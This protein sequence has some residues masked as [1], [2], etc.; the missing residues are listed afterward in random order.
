MAD[1]QIINGRVLTPAGELIEATLGIADGVIGETTSSSF[2]LDARDLLVLPGIID[3]HGDAFERQLMPRPGVGFPIDVALLETDRQMAANG[4]TTAF[5][6]VT[7]SWEPGLRDASMAQAMA[8]ALVALKGQLSVDTRFHLRHE[9]HN[10]AAEAMILEWIAAG[11]IA[12]LSFNDH[13]EDVQADMAKP[14]KVQQYL[15]RT[16]LQRAAWDE[17]VAEVAAHGPDV[18]ASVSRLAAAAREAGI[19]MMSHDDMSPQTRDAFYAMGVL[20]AEF[21]ETEPTAKRALEQGGAVV[22]G[23]PNVVRGKS[24]TTAPNASDMVGK[25]LCTVLASDYY[26]P[27]LALAPFK[28]VERLGHGIAAYWPLIS[29]NPAR[30]LSLHD[31]GSLAPGQRADIVVIDERGSVPRVV[32]TLVAGRIVYLSEG[33]RLST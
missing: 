26:Y 4:I 19:S 9:C 28:L 33:A 2:S 15:N 7:W 24:H 14:L 16:G 3:V 31:R 21:P 13:I 1:G 25:G 5:H 11:K 29:T 12:V 20:V 27:A 23:A 10:L 6:A 8:Q 17:L 18:P 30:A 32:A 22:F